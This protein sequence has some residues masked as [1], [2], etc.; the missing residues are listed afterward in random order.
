MNYEKNIFLKMKFGKNISS[1]GGFLQLLNGLLNTSNEYIKR[2]CDVIKVYIV[3][4]FNCTTLPEA[5][6]S[7]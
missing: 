1:S 7:P 5:E 2:K 6:V 3:E 4:I